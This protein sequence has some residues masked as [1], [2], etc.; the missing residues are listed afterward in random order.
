MITIIT[1]NGPIQIEKSVYES[2]PGMFMD[3][4]T[5][6]YGDMKEICTK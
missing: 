6:S 4:T 3:T 5:R 2:M 1:D